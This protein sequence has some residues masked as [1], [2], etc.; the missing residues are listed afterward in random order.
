MSAARHDF[1]LIVRRVIRGL[2]HLITLITLLS[3]PLDGKLDSSQL[4]S[5]SIGFLLQR[6]S[7]VLFFSRQLGGLSGFDARS[8]GELFLSFGDK[9]RNIANTK[10]SKR[11]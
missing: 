3:L 5:Q 9:S 2:P 7:L 10:P 8:G 4:L 1:W 11:G 6:G